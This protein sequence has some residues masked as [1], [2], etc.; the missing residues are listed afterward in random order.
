M[1]KITAL[2]ITACML[3]GLLAGCAGQKTTEPQT[4]PEDAGTRTITDGVGRQ[5]EVPATVNTIVP[6]GNTPRMITY[7][8]LADKVVGVEQCEHAE[9]PI[10]AYAYINID[11]WKDLPNVG[12]NAL[13]ASEWY[14][15]EL[16]ACDPDVILCTYD[17]E[18]ADNIQTQTGIP[19][20]A[21]A[22]GTLFGEDYDESLR[23]LA[24][25]C[26]VS[27]RAEKVIS[28]ID[29]CLTDL[30]SRTK[31]IADDSKPLVLGAGATFKG[32]HSIDGVYS[33]YPV[34]S[35]L[36]ANDAAIGISDT[37]GG[38][39]VDKEQILSWDPDMIFFDSGS[40]ELV[41]TDF[42]KDS[43]YFNQLKAVKNGELYQWPNST[44]HWSNVEIPL[45]SCYYVGT[46]LYPE[47][48]ADVD[49][50]AKASEIFELFLGEPDYLSVLEQAGAGYGKVTLGE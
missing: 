10:M 4:S 42:A 31:D 32:G 21:V 13:G 27:D 19:T 40:M 29:E 49:F 24:D 5:V 9:S 35:I 12:N 11:K 14:A 43:A 41:N 6:L 44:W 45:V 46:L 15:E 1:K 8:G 47:A 50:E 39:L 3:L 34:F 36:H 30:D 37:V 16:V 17:K 25:V 2:L 18:T 48:F 7:L 26:G 20:I 33:K 28:F 23:V 38:L 22:Q